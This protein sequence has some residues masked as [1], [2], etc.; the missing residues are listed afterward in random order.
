MTAEGRRFRFGVGLLA[1]FLTAALT[2][3][4]ETA[5]VA[6]S[7][8]Q[9]PATASPAPEAPKKQ[10]RG[11]G[12][13]ELELRGRPGRHLDIDV[14]DFPE[15]SKPVRVGNDRTVT[16]VVVRSYMTPYDIVRWARASLY[17]AG[18]RV[19][20]VALDNVDL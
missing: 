10:G 17:G 14:F 2:K 11:A 6:S 3:G 12:W 7:K 9:E 19:L 18:A 20:G 16:R 5:P 8:E 1:L 13:L 15:Q 4:R